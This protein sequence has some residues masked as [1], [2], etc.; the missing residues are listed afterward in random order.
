MEYKTFSEGISTGNQDGNELQTF[1]KIP[2]KATIESTAI[3]LIKHLASKESLKLGAK[4]SLKLITK[5]TKLLMAPYMWP[6]IWSPEIIDIATSKD[7][8]Q[9]WKN[10][11]SEEWRKGAK[12][13]D[14]QVREAVKARGYSEENMSE[15]NMDDPKMS[16]PNINIPRGDYYHPER[17]W[18]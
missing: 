6:L 11:K 17:G 4:A 9:I 16:K 10:F 12:E 1:A 13:R 14:I 5:F 8:R 15:P 3:K 7:V 2:T 18:Y